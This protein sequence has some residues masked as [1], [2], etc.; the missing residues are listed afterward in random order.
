MSTPRMKDRLKTW[1]SRPWIVM[2]VVAVVALGGW[3][4]WRSTS[5]SAAT[6]TTGFGTQVVDVTSG[7]MDQSVTSAGTVAVAQSQ[8]A[9]F[10]SSGTVTAVNVAAG[11]QVKAGDVLATID[12]ASLQSS[13]ASAQSS[14]ATAQAKVSDDTASGAS[15]AQLSADRSA[16]TV[17]P[18]QA[19]RGPGCAGRRLAGGGVRRHRGVGQPHGRPAARFVG[20]GRHLRHGNRQ[21]IGRLRRPRSAAARARAPR[22]ARRAARRRPR[23][24]PR[25]WWS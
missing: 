23:P 4:I 15:S 25:R 18:G 19:H 3:W 7:S 2:P 20:L 17:G 13:V 9:S 21:R 11:Q 8:K 5:S 12:S 24:P 1:A 14:V 6:T 16:L 10:S 22:G